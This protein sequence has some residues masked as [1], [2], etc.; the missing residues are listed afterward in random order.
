MKRFLALLAI[1]VLLLMTGSAVALDFGNIIDMVGGLESIMGS[2]DEAAYGVNEPAETEGITVTLTNVMESKGGSE[3]KPEEGN[4]FVICEFKIENNSN[5]D[6]MISSMM[7]FSASFDDKTYPESIEAL[8]VA[9]FSGKYQLD[10]LVEV[11]KKVNGVVG[12]EVP[13]AWEEMQIR[14]TPEAYT[15]DRLVFVANK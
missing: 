5:E 11:G 4:V 15:G 13:E 1:V 8:G 9:M 2:T 6:L 10:T 14:F 3:Y 7:C 12:Y